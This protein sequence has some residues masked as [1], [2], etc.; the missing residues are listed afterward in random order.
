MG[1][2]EGPGSINRPLFIVEGGTRDLVAY[3]VAP[4]RTV[5]EHLRWR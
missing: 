3:A 2:H 5:T 1:A 4:G